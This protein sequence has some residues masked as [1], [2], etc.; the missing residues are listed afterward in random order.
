[1]ILFLDFDGVLHPDPPQP[2]QRF[3]SLPR[4]VS[5]LRD[6]LEVEIVISSMWREQLS[7][8]EIRSFFPADI[9]ARIIGTTPLT[10]RVEGYAPA[11]REGEIVDWLEQAGRSEEPWIAIDDQHW[12]FTRHKDRLVSCVFYDGLDERVEALL[13]EKLN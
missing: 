6:H 1:M 7:L 12:Q 2:D 13:R 8:D 5:V 11:R 9:A 4:L 3:R 10:P